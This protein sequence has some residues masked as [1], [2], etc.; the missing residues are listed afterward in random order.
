MKKES[1]WTEGEKEKGLSV[2]RQGLQLVATQCLKTNSWAFRMS[3]QM[4][5]S[6]KKKQQNLEYG[7]EIRNQQNATPHLLNMHSNP[8]IKPIQFNGHKTATF[9]LFT[10]HHPSSVCLLDVNQM[11]SIS[12][13][14]RFTTLRHI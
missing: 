13:D 12:E 5:F 14:F 11:G 2:I 1:R 10:L 8:K 9:D 6:G 3:A 4:G 7:Y